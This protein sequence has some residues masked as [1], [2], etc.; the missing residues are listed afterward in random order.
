MKTILFVD[1]DVRVVSALQ[2]T[3]YKDYRIEIAGS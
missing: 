3:L 2:R 1:D